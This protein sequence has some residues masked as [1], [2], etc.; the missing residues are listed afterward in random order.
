MFLGFSKL[1]LYT[2]LRYLLSVLHKE[3][4]ASFYT[5][6]LVS[7]D[8]LFLCMAAGVMFFVSLSPVYPLL[9]AGWGYLEWGKTKCAFSVGAKRT[10]TDDLGA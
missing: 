2:L 3:E 6:L 1:D 5:T 9:K 8:V 4:K 10:R 7:T